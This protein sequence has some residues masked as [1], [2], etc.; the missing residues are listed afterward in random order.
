MA[1]KKKPVLDIFRTLS[2]IDCQDKDFYKNLTEE[3]QKAFVPSVVM[4]WLSGVTDKSGL[5][6]YYTVMTNEIVNIGFWDLYKHPHLQYL[7]M[8]LVGCGNKQGH[9]WIA[10][11]KKIK[12]RKVDE[13][14]RMKYPNINDVELDLLWRINTNDSVRQLA[15]DF[16]YDEKDVKGFVDEFKSVKI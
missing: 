11:P 16:G 15:E 2:A 5:S 14:F 13:L 8:T 7:L 10:G 9:Q 4:R 1:E 12:S 6:E 3:E